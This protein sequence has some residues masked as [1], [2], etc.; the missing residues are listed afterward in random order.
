MREMFS[1]SAS[2]TKSIIRRQLLIAL[3]DPHGKMCTAVGVAV[4]SIAQYDWPEDWPDL[5]PLLL[6][7][8]GDQG[9]VNGVRGA[10]RCLALIFGDLNDKFV[11]KLI[12]ALFTCLYTIVSSFNLW[13]SQ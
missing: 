1:G 8:I 4:A 13:S 7:L 10:L 12:P 2:S 9:N 5:L 3:D 11:P 6:N